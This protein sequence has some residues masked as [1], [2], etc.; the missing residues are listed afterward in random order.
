MICVY[1]AQTLLMN[2]GESL[3]GKNI[4]KAAISK[5]KWVTE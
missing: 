5:I 2:G 3:E 1:D 4:A